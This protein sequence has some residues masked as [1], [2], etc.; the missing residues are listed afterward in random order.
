[1]VLGAAWLGNTR[2]IANIEAAL[3]NPA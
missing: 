3:G 2:L 1:V